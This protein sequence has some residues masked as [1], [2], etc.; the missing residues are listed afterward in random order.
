MCGLLWFLGKH[1]FLGTGNSHL[2]FVLVWGLNGSTGGRK[3][4]FCI[5]ICLVTWEWGQSVWRGHNR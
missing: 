1:V 5:R 2:A 3:G 4:R